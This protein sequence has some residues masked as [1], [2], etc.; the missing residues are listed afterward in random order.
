MGRDRIDGLMILLQTLPGISFT[1]YGDEIGMEDH[2]DISWEDTKDI[3]ACNADED[4]YQPLSRDVARTPFQWDKTENSGFTSGKSW[5]P[6]HPGYVENNLE[7]QMSVN[8]IHYKLF[9]ELTSLRKNATLAL[10]DI[11]FKVLGDNVLAYSRTHEK[12]SYLIA[13]N[14]GNKTENVDASGFKVNLKEESKIL[15]AAPNSKH[16]I[17]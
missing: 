10:G 12:V 7:S 1:Y 6:V 15:L 2:T 16:E 9:K 11:D 13:I 5:L 3:Q 17:K 8:K 14:L 4:S